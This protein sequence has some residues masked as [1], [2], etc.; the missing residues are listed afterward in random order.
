MG[1]SYWVLVNEQ[2]DSHTREVINEYLLSLKVSNKSETTIVKYRRNLDMFF[3]TVNVPLTDLT[4]DEVLNWLNDY[5]K[6]RKP[7]TVALM[8]STLS[9]FFSFCQAE[10]YLD[11][12]LLKR[13]WRPKLPDALPKY[14]TD[15]EV[16]LVKMKAE[17]LPLRD[18]T[19]I[20][21]LLSSGCRRSEVSHLNVS[22]I[23]L[24]KRT[25]EVRGKGKK[26]RTV[27]FS[28]E[29]SLLLKAYLNHRPPSKDD[30]LFLTHS[31][32]RLQPI[33]IYKT[34]VRV[35]KEAE[36]L[37]RFTP[38][39]CRHTFATTMMSRGADLEFIGAELGHTDLNT[40]RVYARVPSEKLRTAYQKIMG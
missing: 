11:Q 34:V 22:D 40:T 13:R 33:G 18:R 26:V 21:F 31:G 25:A 7:K 2:L 35:G 19:I 3:R 8:F 12:P 23:D 24:N 27:H 17:G 29:C 38:H 16:A 5:T 4:S 20:S 14:L 6:G 36:L 10:D 15:K 1:E 39:G 28:I 37:Q 9:T 30:A 32:D